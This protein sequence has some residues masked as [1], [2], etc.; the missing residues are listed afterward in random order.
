[1]HNFCLKHEL[2]Y[3]VMLTAIVSDSMVIVFSIML[4]FPCMVVS[5]ML[6]SLDINCCY[7]D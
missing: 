2:V 5:M 7:E 4:C 1:M 6:F 3:L